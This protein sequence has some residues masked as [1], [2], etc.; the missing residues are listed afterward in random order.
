MPN[1]LAL[2]L[3]FKVAADSKVLLFLGHFVTLRHTWEDK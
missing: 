2:V 1:A 3:G